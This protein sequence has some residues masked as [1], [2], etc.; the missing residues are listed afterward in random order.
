MIEEM[1]AKEHN[2]DV[3]LDVELDVDLDVELDPKDYIK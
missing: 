2:S 3:D 1:L